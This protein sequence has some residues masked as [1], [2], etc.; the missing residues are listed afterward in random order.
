MN[1]W[2]DKLTKQGER[3]AFFMTSEINDLGYIYF[4]R[5]TR[6]NFIIYI[7]FNAL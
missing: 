1:R 7:I 4:I 6:K 3:L 5:K 2:K